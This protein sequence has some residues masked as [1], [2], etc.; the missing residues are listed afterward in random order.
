VIKLYL[1]GDLSLHSGRN[2]PKLISFQIPCGA[3]ANHTLQNLAQP[4]RSRGASS[5]H[6]NVIQKIMLSEAMARH[7][8]TLQTPAF[9]VFRA[10][11]PIIGSSYLSPFTKSLAP[12]RVE[13]CPKV[14]FSS[15]IYIHGGFL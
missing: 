5:L 2:D 6:Q 8:L 14:I 1:L 9:S 15:L 13:N 3:E 10:G 4:L 7:P 12:E 11:Q